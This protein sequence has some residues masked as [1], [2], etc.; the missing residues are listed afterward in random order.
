MVDLEKLAVVFERCEEGGFHAFIPEIPG[1]HS[2]GETIE[3]TTENL[4]DAL[5][6]FLLDGLLDKLAKQK[7][8]ADRFEIPLMDVK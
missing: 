5:Q 8:D 1:I 3:E 4:V 2:Q 6:L 7:Q